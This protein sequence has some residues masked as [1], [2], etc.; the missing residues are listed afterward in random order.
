MSDVMMKALQQQNESLTRQVE[1]LGPE[2]VRVRNLLTEFDQ[3][4][5]QDQAE[6]ERLRDILRTIV[7]RAQSA[8]RDCEEG[9]PVSAYNVAS[10]ILGQIGGDV[11]A[12]TAESR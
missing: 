6:I 11:A 5:D 2:N 7:H 3:R 9:Q 4:H 12:L 10:G 8:K 1:Q